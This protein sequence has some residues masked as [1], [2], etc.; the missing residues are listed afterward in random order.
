[1]IRGIRIA[2]KQEI[3]EAGKEGRRMGGK[4]YCRK[5][6]EEKMKKNGEKLL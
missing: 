3:I 6:K 5:R 1:M 2:K 4:N